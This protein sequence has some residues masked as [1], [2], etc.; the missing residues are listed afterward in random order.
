MR[1]MELHAKSAPEYKAEV[2][3]P[4]KQP[5]L[6]PLP[7]DGM[8]G[9]RSAAHKKQFP[10]TAAITDAKERRRYLMHLFNQGEFCGLRTAGH[11]SLLWDDLGPIEFA[12]LVSQAAIEA[13]FRRGSE[14][15]RRVV[16]L[17]QAEKLYR[18]A[19]KAK[20]LKTAARILETR[21]RLEMPVGIDL[22]TAL[23]GTEA[24]QLVAPK[25]RLISN[26]A[27]DVVYG[28]LQAEES[29]RRQLSAPV[30]IEAEPNSA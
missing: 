25:L 5:K 20:D 24:W 14:Q 8:I 28:A 29:R 6:V 1:H 17:G 11:L 16:L 12:E 15:A 23:A 22:M 19:V 27:F 9:E 7:N 18:Q 10:K 30:T 26:E 2:E 3:L 13:N 21:A 4:P